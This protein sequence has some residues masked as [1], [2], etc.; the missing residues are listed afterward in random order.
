MGESTSNGKST[1]SASVKQ[2]E[3][4]AKRMNNLL[5]GQ[6]GYQKVNRELADIN[7]ELDDM[8]RKVS[9]VRADQLADENLD[10]KPIIRLFW[11]IRSELTA[12]MLVAAAQKQSYYR[13]LDQ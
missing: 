2:I 8:A 9:G 12:K 4:L 3:E 5:L 11:T 13:E 6:A 7:L 10:D 1:R